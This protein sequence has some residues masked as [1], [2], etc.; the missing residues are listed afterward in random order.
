MSAARA[1]VRAAKH[2]LEYAGFRTLTGMLRLLPEAAAMRLGAA[3]G[4]LAG[5]ALGVRRRIVRRNLERAFPGRPPAWRRG[6]ARAAWAHL[7]REAAALLRLGSAGANAV[8]ARTAVVG[9]DALRSALGEGRGVVLVTGHLG[10]WELGGAALS[11]RGV[12]LHAV[13]Q[14]QA[15]PYVRADLT[16]LRKRLGMRVIDRRAAPRAVLQALRAGGVVAFVADQDAGARG[17]FLDFLGAPASTARGPALFALRTGAP[18]F[19]GIALREPGKEHLYTV[20]LERIHAA[21]TGDV[22]ADALRLTSAHVAALERVIRR[23]P[24]QYFWPHRRWKT[25]PA[26]GPRSVAGA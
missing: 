8:R 12:P 15:N 18:L 16:T 25:P 24:E 14:A 10:N 4:L 3:V 20:T 22:R 19:L 2:R 23:A 26:G 6:V 7:G 9:L 1:R 21:C 13:A 5:A 17:L 11:L